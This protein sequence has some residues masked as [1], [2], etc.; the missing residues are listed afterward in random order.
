MSFVS[1]IGTQKTPAN[2]VDVLLGPSLGLPAVPTNVILIGNMGA[3]GGSTGVISASGYSTPYT[4]VQIVNRGSVAA[5]SSEAFLKFGSGSEL[6]KMVIAAVQA[7]AGGSNFPAITA[8]PLASG[9]TTL[10]AQAIA[11]LDPLPGIP[12]VATQFDAQ[13]DQTNTNLLVAEIATMSGALRTPQGQFGAFG[14]GATMATAPLNASTLKEYNTQFFVPIFFYDSGS[15][16]ANPYSVGE[17]AAAAAAVLA[18][19]PVPFNGLDSVAVPG[20]PT[21]LNQADWLTVG[22]GLQSEAVLGQGW[23]PMRVLVSGQVAFVRTVTSRIFLADGVTPA[24]AYFD[25][26]DFESLYFFRDTVATRFAQPDFMNQKASQGNA[27]AAKGEVIRLAQV[28]QDQ[29]MFQAVSEL[30][31]LIQIQNNQQQRGRFDIYVPVNVVP[32]LHE[33]ATDIVGTTLFDNFTA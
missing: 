8:I 11:A 19:N 29:G 16:G 6:A 13:S 22:G 23:V 14:V 28:F 10:N 24:T 1:T 9:V 7:V 27:K 30:S 21:P 18:A 31:P 26:Q 20:V 15:L 17:T 5:A 2:P 32:N 12:F 33:I 3:T 25:V 4:A